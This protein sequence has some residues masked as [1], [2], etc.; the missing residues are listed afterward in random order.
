MPS[1][2]KI[3]KYYP[4]TSSKTQL[5][6]INLFLITIHRFKTQRL[7]YGVMGN[8]FDRL[9]LTW[10]KRGEISFQHLF[11]DETKLETNANQYTIGWKGSILKY[12][13]KLKDKILQVLMTYNRTYQTK[14]LVITKHLN[15]TFMRMK[16]VR[17]MPLNQ[18]VQLLKEIRNWGSSLIVRH[19]LRI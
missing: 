13:V 18:N 7:T 3:Q 12:Q 10:H 2:Q 17:D 11:V 15:T 1:K 6:L 9:I 5:I 14:H 4:P 19:L 16:I 8:L